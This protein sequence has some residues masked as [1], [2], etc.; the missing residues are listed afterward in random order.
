MEYNP[1]KLIV[2]FLARIPLNNSLDLLDLVQGIRLR[3]TETIISYK[4]TGIYR[5]VNLVID[6]EFENQ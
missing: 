6:I 4:S 3:K 5:K 1:I 2:I